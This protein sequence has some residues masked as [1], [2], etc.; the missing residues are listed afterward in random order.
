MQGRSKTKKNWFNHLGGMFSKIEKGLYKEKPDLLSALPPELI[1]LI[2]EQQDDI[3]DVARLAAVSKKM[4]SI[5]KSTSRAD[6]QESYAIILNRLRKNHIS[7]RL[8]WINA[9]IDWIEA[10]LEEKKEYDHGNEV[11]RPCVCVTAGSCAVC[12]AG[13]GGGFAYA[14]GGGA[15]GGGLAFLIGAGAGASIPIGFLLACCVVG[16]GYSACDDDI[17]VLQKR[18]FQLLGDQQD[19]YRQ[20]DSLNTLQRQ[21]DAEESQEKMRGMRFS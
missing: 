21:E 1:S 16:W 2:V 17:E 5:V 12:G 10:R 7:E 8:S 18:W 13:A 3:R 19:C 4:N 11:C 6:T 20:L 14:V 15:L 9:N